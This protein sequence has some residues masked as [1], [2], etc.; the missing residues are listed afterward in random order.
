MNALPTNFSNHTKNTSPFTW[1]LFYICAHSKS[2]YYMKKYLLIIFTCCIQFLYGQ[3][4]IEVTLQES[5]SQ[6]ELAGQFLGFPINNGIEAYKFLY[7][8]TDTDGSIDIASG[9]FIVPITDITNQE[10]PFLVYQHGTVSERTQVPSNI[11]NGERQLIY[12]LAGQGYHTIAADYLGLGDSRRTIH[13]YLHAETQASA[14]I[15]LVI[16]A[17]TFLAQEDIPFNQQL[18]LTGYSQGGH[19]SMAMHQVLNEQP[20]EGLT[21]VAGSHMSGIYNMEGEILAASLIEEVYEFPSYLVWIIVSYQSVYGN[22]YQ[23]L[24]EVFR[25]EYVTEIRGFE[26]GSISQGELNDLLVAELIRNHD[27][28]IPNFMLDE[29]YLNEFRSNPNHPLAIAL[30]DNDVFDWIPTA[31]MRM[32]YCMA[33][34]Q[35]SF[36]NATFTDSIMNAAG[37]ADVLAIDVNSTASH[38]GCIIPAGLNTLAFFENF[39][40]R[41]ILSS[42]REVD[43][44]LAFEIQPNPATDYLQINWKNLNTS[45]VPVNFRLNS[46]SGQ[47]VLQHFQNSPQN[48]TIPL[49]DISSG[50]YLLEV[51]SEKGFWTEKVLIKN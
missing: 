30:R 11:E 4:I 51:Q 20:I 44:D 16:A 46:L 7:E 43:S 38:G 32:M 5:L 10:F 47:V 41:S 23:N 39:A 50:L 36:T 34:E 1:F 42:T 6:E 24:E 31:P 33:D 15:D 28:S 14:A 49:N 9:L 2:M 26:E 29:T 19:A 40:E 18:F 12:F 3:K 25:P 21:V 45:L 37:A 8:T 13:P 48:I 27:A 35:V 22:L 17:R